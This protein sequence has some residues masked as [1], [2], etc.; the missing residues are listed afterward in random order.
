[1]D[2]KLVM[3]KRNGQRKD[4]PIQGKTTTIGRGEDCALRVPLLN[5]SREHCQ[6]IKGDDEL[7]VKDL[8]SSNGTY[9]NNRRITE[10]VLKA[11]DRL[12]I[13]PVVLT[14]Q[15]DGV[16]EEITPV[17]SPAE[18]AAA[19]AT[20]PLASEDEEE[21]VELEADMVESGE[22]E[23]SDPISALEAMAAESDQDEEQE[24]K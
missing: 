18:I 22:G 14:V 10:S 5:I 19:A 24:D 2:V 4:F 21:I 13:G 16:P 1:M 15:V 9:V 23:Q 3:F 11:G 7:R 20:G 12:A 6:L 17:K 8:A